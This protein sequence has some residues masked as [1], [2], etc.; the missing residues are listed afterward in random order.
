MKSLPNQNEAIT[1]DGVLNDQPRL[2]LLQLGEFL[3]GQIIAALPEYADLAA[4]QAVNKNPQVK[5][6]YGF[7]IGQGLAAW[8]GSDFVLASDYT[9]LIT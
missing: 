4:V 5:G 8:N 7:V 3:D 2:Y 6:L 1:K 9:T